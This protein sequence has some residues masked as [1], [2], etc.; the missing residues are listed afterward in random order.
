MKDINA[1]LWFGYYP[2]PQNGVG[3]MPFEML[4]SGGLANQA[5]PWAECVDLGARLLRSAIGTSMSGPGPYVVPISG[6]MDSR[7]I[8]A[9]ALEHYEASSIYT[10]TFGVPGTYDFDI[11]NMVAETVGTRHRSFDLRAY[12]YDL[13]TL[14]DVSMRVAAR[15]A[16]FQHA[17]YREIESQ[18]GAAV[19]ISGFMGEA[20]SGAH[21]LPIADS[22]HWGRAKKAFALRNRYST[23]LK[24]SEAN[25]D[26][27][28]ALP[29]EPLINQNVLSYDDQLDFA[30]R[31]KRY[32]QP[33]VVARGFRYKTPFLD[34]PWVQYILSL[35]RGYRYGQSMYKAILVHAFPRLFSLPTKTCFGLPLNAARWRINA[36]RRLHQVKARSR[37]FGVNIFGPSPMTNYIEF[38]TALRERLDLRTLTL[39]CLSALEERHIVDWID[40]DALWRE[41]QT[42]RVDHSSALLLLASLEINLRYNGSMNAN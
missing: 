2:I 35:P 30:I 13:E 41:H 11:G 4:P 25:F 9:C 29:V 21:L 36:S 15:T 42:G 23:N 17:P 26:P 3:N 22:E 18:L 19:H 12:S 20:L 8:L 33:L 16:L 27:T 5:L 38:G 37:R 1:F 32:I 14:L 24:L 34:P 6:G 40:I 10:Y 28:T 39:E 31:Q 7:A